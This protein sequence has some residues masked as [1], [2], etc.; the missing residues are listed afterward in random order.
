MFLWKITNSYLIFFYQLILLYFFQNLAVNHHREDSHSET[1]GETATSQDSGNGSIET[2]ENH[3]KSPKNFKI[4]CHDLEK[5]SYTLS[6]SSFLVA[7]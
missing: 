4:I 3:G 7:I 5:L 1:S 6:V 2:A